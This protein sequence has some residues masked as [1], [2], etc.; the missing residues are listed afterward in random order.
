VTGRQVRVRIEGEALKDWRAGIMRLD[1]S[2]GGK[3]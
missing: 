1:I 3:R 2:Q